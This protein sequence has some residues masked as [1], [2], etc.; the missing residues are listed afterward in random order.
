MQAN[1]TEQAT[2]NIAIA[3]L[4]LGQK[5][6]EA[7]AKRDIGDRA[8]HGRLKAT[9]SPTRWRSCRFRRSSRREMIDAISAW[10]DRLSTTVTGLREQNAA[11]AAMDAAAVALTEGARSLN[12]TFTGDADRLGGT[13]RT[14]L[15]VGATVGLLLGCIAAFV[16]ARQITFPLQRL[17][18]SMIRLAENPAGGGV[19]EAAR[20]DELGDMA[21][22]AN[23]FVAEIVA[24][25]TALRTP[26]A[27]PT[28][29]S[30][31]SPHAGDTDPGREA[32]L[33]RP[34]RRRRR[35]RDQHA[36]SASR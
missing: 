19:S 22:A 3:T 11:I 14:I 10:R 34:T 7:L 18:Q 24:R 30:R 8:G 2:Q 13:I 28:R 1:E 36:A 27:A 4:K 15:L 29:R 21:R 25:E 32:R 16:V 17:Q 23:F 26:S 33:A 31:N 20:K 6:S 12:D 9:R 5:T 35:A